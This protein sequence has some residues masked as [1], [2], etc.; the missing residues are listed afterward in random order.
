MESI[1]AAFGLVFETYTL[2]VILLAALFGL[3]VGAVPGLTATMATALLVAGSISASAQ[4]AD[5]ED[6]KAKMKA[7]EQ[8]LMEMKQKIADLE[9][10]KAAPAPV[11]AP[12]KGAIAVGWLCVS[13]FINRGV[14]SA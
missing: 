14:A 6:L 12:A 5:V 8:T 3:F 10:E 1:V 2:F 13:T 4:N 11:A 9:K 7:M